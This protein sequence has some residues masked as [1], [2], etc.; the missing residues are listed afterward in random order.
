MKDVKHLASNR[1]TNHCWL[2]GRANIVFIG[3]ANVA[4]QSNCAAKSNF[5]GC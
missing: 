2:N 3:R 4:D 5:A 1:F